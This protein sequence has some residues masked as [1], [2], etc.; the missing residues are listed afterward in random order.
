VRNG[1]TLH[2]YLSSEQ[3]WTGRLLFDRARHQSIMK[4]PVDYPRINQ[5]PEWFI[6]PPEWH[7]DG[8]PLT[9]TPGKAQRLKIDR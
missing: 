3:P 9:L 2:L 4:L 5:F 6:L 7:P 8:M 1:K